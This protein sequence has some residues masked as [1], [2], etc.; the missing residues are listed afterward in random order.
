LQRPEPLRRREPPYAPTGAG[1]SVSCFGRERELATLLDHLADASAGRGRV[2]FVSGEPG[3][4]KSRL[5][6]ELAARAASRG[7]HVLVG[8]CLEGVGALPF[9]PFVEAVE[10]FLDGRPA[11][12]ALAHLL[13]DG[14]AL[15]GRTLQPDE[16]RLRLLDGMARFLVGCGAQSC[17]SLTI[18]TGP[19][20]A[21]SRCS[22]MSPA[23]PL[24][25]G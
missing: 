12:E 22:G 14:R 24:G 3:I 16:L 1:Q 7:A 9:H 15:G 4:G 11:P 17:S 25:T 13:N 8:R 2:T 20:T 18:C 5:L 19:T 23:A 6:A 21:R 10:A